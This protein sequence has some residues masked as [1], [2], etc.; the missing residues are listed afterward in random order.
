MQR[1]TTSTT[2]ANS[3]RPAAAQ[4]CRFHLDLQLE[5]LPILAALVLDAHLRARRHGEA[6]VGDLDRERLARLEGVRE[7]AELLDELR[8]GGDPLDVAV[9][10]AWHEDYL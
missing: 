2:S 10:A 8:A 7:A 6:L 9:G 3:R 1:S 5:L 4:P